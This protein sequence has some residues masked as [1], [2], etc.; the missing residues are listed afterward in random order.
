VPRRRFFGARLRG[1]DLGFRFADLVE[2]GAEAP[3]IG[4]AEYQ[5]ADIGDLDFFG[6]QHHDLTQRLANRAFRDCNNAFGAYAQRRVF[7]AAGSCLRTRFKIS[8]LSS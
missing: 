4:P 5:D 8:L 2:P 1:G 6:P 7:L 3:A